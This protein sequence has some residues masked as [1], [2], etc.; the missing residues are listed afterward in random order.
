MNPSALRIAVLCPHFRPD[1]APTGAVMTRI[2]E[3]LAVLGHEIH[4][5]TSLPWYRRHAV[6]AG[7]DGRW[8]QR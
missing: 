1:T 5:T 8:V 7:W 6:E 3:E 4:V 2:V